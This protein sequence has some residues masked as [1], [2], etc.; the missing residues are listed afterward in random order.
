MIYNE[1]S[2]IQIQNNIVSTYEIYSLPQDPRHRPSIAN[3]HLGTVI[4]SKEVYM[5]GLYNGRQTTTHRAVIPSTVSLNITA[6]EPPS[7]FSR[8]YSLNVA[9]GT[10]LQMFIVMCCVCVCVKYGY[11]CMYAYMYFCMYVCI[12]IF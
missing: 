5:N 6:T 9:Q 7:R 4:H 10:Y 3:G 8:T 1:S 2:S 12:F 11:L